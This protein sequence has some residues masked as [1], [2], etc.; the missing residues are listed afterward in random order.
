MIRFVAS[1]KKQT[2]K[3]QQTLNP[4][5]LSLTRRTFQGLAMALL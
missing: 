2:N 5:F 1:I 3:T 4:E